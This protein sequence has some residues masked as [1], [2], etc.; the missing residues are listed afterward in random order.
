MKFGEKNTSP[1]LDFGSFGLSIKEAAEYFKIHE[2]TLYRLCQSGKIKATRIG[3]QW[4]ISL[5]DITKLEDNV[6]TSSL[7]N[8]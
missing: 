8:V 1:V 7:V 6:V 3:I 4:R 5:Q 2:Q